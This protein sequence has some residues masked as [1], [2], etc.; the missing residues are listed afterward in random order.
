MVVGGGKMGEALVAGLLRTGWAPPGAL[1]VVEIDAARRAEL[2]GRHPG[3]QVVGSRRRTPARGRPV[4]RARCWRSSR[5]TPRGSCAPWPRPWVE[6]GA[7]DRGRRQPGARSSPGWESRSAVVRAM[8]NMPALVGAG[9]RPS[10]AGR[11]AGPDDLAWAQSVLEAVGT[12]VTV[13]ESALDA[14][15]GLSGSGPAYVFLLA[16]ALIDAGVLVGLSPA[17]RPAAGGPDP[18]GVGPPADRDRRRAGRPSGPR[19]PRPGGTTAAGLAGARGR[20]RAP[21]RARGGGGGHPAS[22][23]S[24]AA[25]VRAAEAVGGCLRFDG[26]I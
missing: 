11:A 1:V 19:S 7:L 26:V 15:T 23:R 6:P 20:R 5:P 21:R 4:R 8:P 14:V 16:E 18:A 24:S 2:A 10:P 12:V 13:P 17:G 3:V 9:R 25:R 22:P